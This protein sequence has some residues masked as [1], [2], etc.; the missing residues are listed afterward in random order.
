MPG[1]TKHEINHKDLDIEDRSGH[2]YRRDRGEAVLLVVMGVM[3]IGGMLLMAT[4]GGHNMMP[5]HG[6]HGNTNEKE[7]PAPAISAPTARPPDAA[8]HQEAHGGNHDN[9]APSAPNGNAP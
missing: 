3:M 2:Q 1:I 7:K 9:A 5:W 4:V 8:G 6:D